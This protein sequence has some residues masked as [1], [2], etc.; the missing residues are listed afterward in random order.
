MERALLA[1]LPKGTVLRGHS[2][3]ALSSLKLS[4][5]GLNS[6]VLLLPANSPVLVLASVP[7]LESL[8]IQAL[9]VTTSMLVTPPHP[10]VA[11]SPQSVNTPLESSSLLL[12]SFLPPA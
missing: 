1:R 11:S 6:L 10:S 7:L 8:A 12:L 2:H 5:A 3:L 9:A 4:V